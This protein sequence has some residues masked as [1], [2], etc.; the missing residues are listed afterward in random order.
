MKSI[1]FI[2]FIAHTIVALDSKQSFY[3]RRAPATPGAATKIQQFCF[4]SNKILMGVAINTTNYYTQA[5]LPTGNPALFILISRRTFLKRALKDG[6]KET[7][8]FIDLE[9]YFLPARNFFR[10]FMRFPCK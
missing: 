4:S 5:Q 10:L 8:K 6:S 3:Y 1:D 7:E 9:R 2:S